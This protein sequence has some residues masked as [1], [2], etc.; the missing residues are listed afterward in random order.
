MPNTA[1]STGGSIALSRRSGFAPC[2]RLLQPDRGLLHRLPHDLPILR[3]RG[4]QPRR[5]ATRS[6]VAVASCIVHS[7]RGS[8]FFARKLRRALTAQHL[9]GSSNR[10]VPA[11]DNATCSTG[12][13][14]SR[15]SVRSVSDRSRGPSGEPVLRLGMPRADRHAERAMAGS[16]FGDDR[17]LLWRR[18]DA[19]QRR[20]TP[21]VF[22]EGV[23][24]LTPN[25]DATS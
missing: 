22:G 5:D 25:R 24:F 20:P 21:I 19:D 4:Q 12:K 15:C 17:A 3:C 14:A 10:I 23:P 18:E 2:G 13:E 16:P 8:Q 9:V 11:G 7:D 6:G 1:T